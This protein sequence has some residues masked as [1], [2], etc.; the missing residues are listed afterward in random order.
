MNTEQIAQRLVALCREGKFEQAQNELFAEDAVSIEPEGLPPG[1]L[2]SVKG[3][4]EI[5]AKGVEFQARTEAVHALTVSD[6]LVAGNW[7]SVKMTL[8]I[9]RRWA[10]SAFITSAKARSCRSSSSTTPAAPE[11][12]TWR[13]CD[14]SRRAAV[15]VRRTPLPGGVLA[16]RRHRAACAGTSPPAG[17]PIPRCGSDAGRLRTWMARVHATLARHFGDA[18]NCA[19][20]VEPFNATTEDWPPWIARVTASK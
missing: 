3:L 5:R 6:P 16:Q 1:A 9:T 2:G 11:L 7:F 15:R 19:S 13:G 8:D 12:G 10:R 17:A 4:E 14:E 20:S 18:W